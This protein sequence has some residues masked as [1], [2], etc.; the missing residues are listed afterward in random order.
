MAERMHELGRGVRRNQ[1]IAR[2]GEDLQSL[3]GQEKWDGQDG[4][5]TAPARTLHSRVIWVIMPVLPAGM[6]TSQNPPELKAFSVA[7]LAVKTVSISLGCNTRDELEGK[8]VV[9]PSECRT[10]W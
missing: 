2:F 8:L 4:N 1:H 6:R 10:C 9:L 7:V 5:A 3:D